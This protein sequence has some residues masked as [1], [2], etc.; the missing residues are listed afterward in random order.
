MRRET[1]G[2]DFHLNS[3]FLQ[4][5]ELFRDVPAA[6]L[7]EIQAA[8]SQRRVAAGQVVFRQGDPAGALYVVATGRLRATQTTADGQQVIIRYLGPGEVAGYT[9]LSGGGTHPGTV[10]AVE[11]ALL[12][13]WTGAAMKKLMAEHSSIAMNAVA[14]LGA[15]YHEMQ[16]RIRELST[17]K[18]ERR[19]AHTV[20]RL[21]EQAGRRTARG[22][23]I[24]IPL[25]RQDL[26]EMSGTTLHTVSRTLSAWEEQKIVSCGRRRVVV[27]KANVLA[28]IA[29]V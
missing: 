26:A 17:E 9:T 1:G 14:F 23:E 4:G 10:T 7:H 25:S 24:A 18:V 2:M 22:I 28:S 16:V 13:S 11:D 19:I 15:R 5:T 3:E 6:A 29:E 21:A 8:S 27:A 12:I 20:L